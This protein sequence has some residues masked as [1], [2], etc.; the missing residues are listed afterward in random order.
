MMWRSPF[1]Q[2]PLFRSAS[3]WSQKFKWSET[4]ALAKVLLEEFPDADPVGVKTHHFKKMIENVDPELATN[5]RIQEWKGHLQAL[6][7][8]WKELYERKMH[9]AIVLPGKEKAGP[10]TF[11]K[12]GDPGTTDNVMYDKHGRIIN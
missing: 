11:A 4:Q 2:L 3:A 9:D 1:R 8:P 10:L 6:Q 5:T 7:E 12:T